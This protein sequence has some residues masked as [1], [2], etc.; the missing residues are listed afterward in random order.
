MSKINDYL[1][2]AEVFFL[3]TVDGDQTKVRPGHTLRWTARLSS[4]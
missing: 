3:A 2:Q 4:V 1:T